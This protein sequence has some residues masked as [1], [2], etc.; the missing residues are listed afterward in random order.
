M[1]IW[2]TIALTTLSVAP[3]FAHHLERGKESALGS[4]SHIGEIC[5]VALRQTLAP[6][7]MLFHAVLLVGLLYAI[8]DRWVHGRRTRWTLSQLE[9]T[10]PAAGDVWWCAAQAAGV[11]PSILRIVGGLPNPAFTVGWLKPRVYL[12]STLALRLS[13]DELSAVLAHEGAHV[14]NRD[15]LRLSAYRFLACV[16]FWIPA[17]RRMMD[18]VIDDT[19]VQAD[20]AAAASA[21]GVRPL[22]LASALVSVASWVATDEPRGEVTSRLL[23]G[24]VGFTGRDLL[25]RRVRRLAGEAPP[26]VTHLT[27]RSTLAAVAA[28]ALL[29]ASGLIVAH[30]LAAQQ[31]AHTSAAGFQSSASTGWSPTNVR[32]MDCTRHS[33]FAQ[34]HIFC[35]GDLTPCLNRR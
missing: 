12:A 1:L 21:A 7:H 17:F 14:A 30:P 25:S 20:D 22:V 33:G 9:A 34:F 35:P 8:Y 27:Q 11:D 2:G 28:L 5:L 31:M 4:T 15:P 23:H 13:P 16:F 19:E 32:N 26:V 18:D 10:I 24:T 6:V 3:V 29:W